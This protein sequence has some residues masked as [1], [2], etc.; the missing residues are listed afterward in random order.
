MTPGPGAYE[1]SLVP[2]ER[3]KVCRI[4]LRK[5]EI[6]N[7]ILLQKK[8]AP[9]GKLVSPSAVHSTYNSMYHRAAAAKR[10]ETPAPGPGHYLSSTAPSS[11]PSSAPS[12]IAPPHL[13]SR[14]VSPPPG[15]ILLVV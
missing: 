13:R 12:P 3:P 14:T 1:A 2:V 15:I 9:P 7:V 4:S 5:R 8:I 10:E 11:S 6:A